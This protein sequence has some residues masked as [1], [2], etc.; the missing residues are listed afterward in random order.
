MEAQK[1]LHPFRVGGPARQ[2]HKKRL[3]ALWP[4]AS[5]E[6]FLVLRH[7]ATRSWAEGV[8]QEPKFDSVTTLCQSADSA[9]MLFQKDIVSETMHKS[10]LLGGCN[11]VYAWACLT[12]GGITLSCPK[13]N[14][15]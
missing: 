15:P 3:R 13:I 11:Y 2:T 6:N 8:P 1:N 9:T 10:A 4:L 5:A 7:G 12:R 14:L